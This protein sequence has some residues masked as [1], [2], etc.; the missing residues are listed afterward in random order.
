MFFFY[1]PLQFDR[2]R[3]TRLQETNACVGVYFFAPRKYSQVFRLAS[4][5]LNATVF[6]AGD[7]AC[8]VA[9]VVDQSDEALAA[10]WCTHPRSDPPS[11]V[12]P[13]L[14]L[15]LAV[16]EGLKMQSVRY[17]PAVGCW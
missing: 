2:A 9:R 12:V 17:I 16:M 10:A 6:T 15:L 3:S 5:V 4:D 7:V 11:L 8:A 14:C 1:P 13:K